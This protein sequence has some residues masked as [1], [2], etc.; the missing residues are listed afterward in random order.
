MKRIIN[1]SLLGLI[2]LSAS[3]PA[4]A[5]TKPAKDL[6]VCLNNSNGKIM[7][8]KQCKYGETSLDAEAIGALTGISKNSAVA[9]GETGS[10]GAQ[11]AT[12][13]QGIPGLQGAAGTQGPAGP[14]GF[15][16]A[17]G[18]KGDKGDPGSAGPQGPQGNTGAAG[19]TGANGPQGATGPQGPIGISGYEIKT[20]EFSL[21][22]GLW[23]QI[24]TT[25]S[26]G[27]SVLGGGVD[28]SRGPKKL[29]LNLSSPVSEGGVTGWTGAVSNPSTDVGR[30]TVTAICAWVN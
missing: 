16:G 7:A 24:T 15:T 18:L 28:V 13:P 23:A 25:C 26:G 20:S 17:Q 3:N 5:Q 27:K 30:F 12:G 6:R 2:A 9:K 1:I 22:A 11:G 4:L 10:P 29:F 14:Q 8:K 21:G 19:A